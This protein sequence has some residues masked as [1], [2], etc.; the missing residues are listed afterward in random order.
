MEERLDRFVCNKEWSEIFV[1]CEASNLD[2]W[3]SDHYP[4]LMVV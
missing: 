4:V 2:T 3:S 1:D